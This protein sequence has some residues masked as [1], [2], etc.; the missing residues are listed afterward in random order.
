M[1]TQTKQ[2][3]L[4]AN[5]QALMQQLVFLAGQGY[6]YYYVAYLPKEKEHKFPAI[7]TKLIAK[8]Q[9]NVSKYQRYRL[10]QKNRANFMYLR[11][12]HIVVI[13]HTNG[14]IPIIE[15]IDAFKNIRDS[16]IVI[17]LSKYLSLSVVLDNGKSTV[18][19]HKE[20]YRTF[21][22]MIE[23]YAKQQQKRKIIETIQ[24]LNGI[25]AYRGVV[26]QKVLLV[27]YALKQLEFHGTSANKNEFRIL[28]R[29]KLYKVFE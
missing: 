15:G 8:Y 16:S 12:E 19:L 23:G 1:D 29:R 24:K 3:Y 20:S 26:E 7:D 5:W 25:P 13:L 28:K 9:T 2:P 6:T 17:Q 22:M 4:V 14:D 21:K 27:E 11:W 10:K 18:K